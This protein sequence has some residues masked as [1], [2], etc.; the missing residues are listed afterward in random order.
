MKYF[1]ATVMGRSRP[2]GVHAHGEESPVGH[3]GET[4]LK[5]S[6]DEAQPSL[7]E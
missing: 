7:F 3:L 4:S 6:F 2:Q 5:L 1:K